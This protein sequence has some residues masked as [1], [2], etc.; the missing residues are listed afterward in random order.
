MRDFV[1]IF[2]FATKIFRI[3]DL[4]RDLQARVFAPE[5]FGD[6]T[7][8]NEEIAISILQETKMALERSKLVGFI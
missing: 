4:R 8:L 5:S 6:E 2:F 3:G 1:C 7:F